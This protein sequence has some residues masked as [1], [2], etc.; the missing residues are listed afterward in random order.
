VTS[1]RKSYQ[2][3]LT[4]YSSYDSLSDTEELLCITTR[5]FFC[6]FLTIETEILLHP[7][8]KMTEHSHS[9]DNPC[10]PSPKCFL[11]HKP[12]SKPMVLISFGNKQVGGRTP[13]FL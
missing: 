11:E 9:S 8:M 13:H 10:D 5:M 2:V 4:C 1:F 3:D 6:K 7:Q 12:T